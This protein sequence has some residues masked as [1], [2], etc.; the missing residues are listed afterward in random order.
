MRHFLLIALVS[1]GCV[2]TS[3]G[4]GDDDMQLPDGGIVQRT[5]PMP[6]S[7]AAPA[8][9]LTAAKAEMCNVSGSMGALH[10]YKLAA[11]LP[12]TMNYVQVELWDKTGAFGTELVHPGTFQITGNEADYTR[13]GVCVRGLGAK[14]VT[15][16]QKEYFATGGTVNVT[17]VGINGQ[18]IAA[19]LSNISFVEIDPTSHSL[20]ASGCTASV[21][22]ATVTGTVVQIGG[23]GTGG[24]GGGGGG[25]C[26][27]GIAE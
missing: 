7:T 17:A 6:A 23:T 19:T 11:A 5:C 3:P 21:A 25:S 20:V 14:G 10:W 9:P 26:P 12:G 2:G 16:Q 4:G 27:V 8:G 18:P 24:G 1:V 15:G 13:C 22:G